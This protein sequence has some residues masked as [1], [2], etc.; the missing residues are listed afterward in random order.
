MS[1][2]RKH[3]T[4]TIR[5]PYCDNLFATPESTNKALPKAL[6]T[7]TTDSYNNT[8]LYVLCPHCNKRL[9]YK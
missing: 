9:R 5:C 4:D 6:L 7:K 8:K 1:Y 3:V 2:M